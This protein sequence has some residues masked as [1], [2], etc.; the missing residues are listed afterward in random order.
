M[1]VNLWGVIHGVRAFLPR[2]PA[3]GD[4]GHIVD[5][6]SMAGPDIMRSSHNRREA[7]AEQ[8]KAEPMGVKEGIAI[9]AQDLLELRNATLRRG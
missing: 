9:R 6:A 4:E 5:T 7:L 3:G 1:S 2:L 8:G